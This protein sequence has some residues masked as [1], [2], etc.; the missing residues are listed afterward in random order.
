M[1]KTNFKTLVFFL[2]TAA[3]LIF[4]HFFGALRPVESVLQLLINPLVSFSQSGA[5]RISLFFHDQSVKGDLEGRI[6]ILEKD[7]QESKVENASLKRLEEENASL[8]QHLNFFSNRKDFRYVMANVVAR[9]VFAGNNENVGDI[10]IDKGRDD[11]VFEGL[12][13]LNSTGA[14]IGKVDWVGE[15]SSRVTMTVSSNCRLAVSLQNKKNT[16]G[17]AEGNLGLTIAVNF[18][19]QDEEVNVGDN[20]VTSGLENNIPP[21]LLVGSVSDVYKGSNEIW[22]KI[23]VEPAQNSDNLITV[24]VLL[25]KISN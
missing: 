19:P 21:G 25:P 24:S 16:I 17:L 12:I 11:G 1:K 5:S 2:A 22:Q 23:T 4:L 6:K 20:L 3:L 14:V 10:L 9:N 18:V 13:V 7:L 8:R 15:K